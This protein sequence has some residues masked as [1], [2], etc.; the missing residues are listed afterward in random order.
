MH[1]VKTLFDFSFLFSFGQND[2]LL[3]HPF[4]GRLIVK[5]SRKCIF[6]TWQPIQGLR[7]YKKIKYEAFVP[8]AIWHVLKKDDY[9]VLNKFDKNE[10]VPFL[11]T[12]IDFQD[13]RITYV[14]RRPSFP[15]CFVPYEHC[16][17]FFK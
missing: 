15:R 10:L 13:V 14:V 2:S 1:Y 11:L 12:R 6:Y 3:D 8:Y 4:Y 16:K 5:D 7:K 17:G 9:V